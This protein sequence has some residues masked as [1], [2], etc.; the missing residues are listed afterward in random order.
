MFLTEDDLLEVL[1]LVG[2]DDLDVLVV[3]SSIS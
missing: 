2:S 1:E 3:Q